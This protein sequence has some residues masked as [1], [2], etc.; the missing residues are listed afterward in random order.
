MWERN[1]DFRVAKLPNGAWRVQVLSCGA[2]IWV[3]KHLTPCP[4]DDDGNLILDSHRADVLGRGV[5]DDG[6]DVGDW[7]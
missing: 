6:F 2:K 3:N 4:C 5:L 1:P 7:V